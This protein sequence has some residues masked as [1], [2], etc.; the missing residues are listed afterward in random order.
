MKIR[1]V[2]PG[3]GRGLRRRARRKNKSSSGGGGVFIVAKKKSTRRR[4]RIG[5]SSHRRR[6]SNPGFSLGRVKRRNPRRRRNPGGVGGTIRDISG[7]LLWGTGGAVSA[8]A[9]P[10]LVASS[11]NSGITGYAMNGATAWL[12]GM[13]IGKFAG[14]Q[15]GAHF[16]AGG[17]IATGLR[18]FNN[19]F[20]SS[21]PIGLSGDMGY[22]IENS[23]PLPTSGSGPYLLNNGY[24]G[25]P[26]ASGGG[27]QMA[28]PVAA[29]AA[30]ATGV[31]SG[32]SADTP[33][34]WA[35]RWAA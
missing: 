34:R 17:L 31:A 1:V 13:L 24:N 15:A 12:G 3:S 26:M 29:T 10:G 23:F 7:L 35:D 28:L 8:L 32:G 33:A 2:N 5:N 30:A 4:R 19:F 27:G 6:R 22:Y 14:P 18:I 25:S 20:G 21:F 9:V 16:L 11:M